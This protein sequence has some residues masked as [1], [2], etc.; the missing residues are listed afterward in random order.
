MSVQIVIDRPTAGIK[1]DND[2]APTRR[3]T[4]SLTGPKKADSGMMAFLIAFVAVVVVALGFGVWYTWV[5][6]DD[7]FATGGKKYTNGRFMY[8]CTLG[9]F[10]PLV[11]ILMTAYFYYLCKKKA[12]SHV[13]VKAKK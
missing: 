11:A 4:A 8:C 1:W 7:W 10:I 12:D 9:I 13:D 6:L 5:F 3:I 2:F